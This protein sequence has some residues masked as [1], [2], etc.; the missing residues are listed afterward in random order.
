M[1][2]TQKLGIQVEVCEGRSCSV[3]NGPWKPLISHSYVYLVNHDLAD[4]L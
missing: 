1:V 3:A 4:Y 2:P